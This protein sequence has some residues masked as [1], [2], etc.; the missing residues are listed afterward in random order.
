MIRRGGFVAAQN[1]QMRLVAV[2]E[3]IFQHMI[4]EEV[5]DQH[6]VRAAELDHPPGHGRPNQWHAKTIE[7]PLL[8]IKRHSSDELRS[9]DMSQ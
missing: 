2:N 3:R 7:L 9:G 1:L 6:Q 5:D 4:V 8:A